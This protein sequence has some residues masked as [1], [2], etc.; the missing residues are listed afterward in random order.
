ML[1]VA[2]ANLIEEPAAGRYAMHDLLRAHAAELAAALAA[3]ERAAAL[4]RLYDHYRCAAAAAMD[5]AFPHSRHHR[6]RFAEPG[7]PQ[8]H[9]PDARAAR[10]WLGAGRLCRR[11]RRAPDGGGA[12]LSPAPREPGWQ[13]PDC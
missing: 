1:P 3:D 4:D 10:D 7:T 9:F 6:P 8:P 11:V 5:T 13:S 12:P 2:R